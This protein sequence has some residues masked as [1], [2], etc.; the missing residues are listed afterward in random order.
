MVVKVLIADDHQV[1]RQGLQGFLKL[2]PG[3]EVVGIAVNGLEAVE[4]SRLL[5]PDV[6]LMDLLMP[7]MDGFAA[8][9]VIKQ[10]FPAVKIYILSSL[11]DES[12]ISKGL[13]AG[14]EG[15]FIKGKDI[16][17]IVEVLKKV[18]K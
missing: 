14:A 7:V 3:I 13:L 1:V 2:D 17:K 11:K 5:H 6:V 12:S 8:T 15:Y 16:E 10:E 18:N 9:T 4:K